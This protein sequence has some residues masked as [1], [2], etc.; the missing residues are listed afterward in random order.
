M[1]SNHAWHMVPDYY[2]ESRGQI[3]QS[4]IIH[5]IVKL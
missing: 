3:E 5:W 2:L 4:E 1:L